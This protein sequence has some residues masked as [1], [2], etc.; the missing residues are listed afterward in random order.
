MSDDFDRTAYFDDLLRDAPDEARDLAQVARMHRAQAGLLEM[1]NADQPLTDVLRG[2][3]SEVERLIPDALAAIHLLSSEGHL[4]VTVGPSLPD[5]FRFAVDE[6]AV[7]LRVE[8]RRSPLVDRAVWATDVSKDE[9]WA[10][11]AA[12]AESHGI[13]ACWT[14]PA[15]DPG[16]GKTLA[17]LS[18]YSG[19]PRTPRPIEV[20]VLEDMAR[21]LRIAIVTRR[22]E[23]QWLALAEQNQRNL[24]RLTRL[25]EATSEGIFGTDADGRCTFINPAALRMLGIPTAEDAL[26]K[27]IH[28]L[29]RHTLPDGSDY[30][31]GECPIVKTLR[32]GQ[33]LTAHDELLIQHDGS[34]LPVMLS[35]SPK[36]E[37]KTGEVIGAV[38]VFDD[39][40]EQ[41]EYQRRLES[42]L[43]SKDE[44]IASIAHE[45]RTPLTA[46]LGFSEVLG[47]G[48]RQMEL[49]EIG[50]IIKL[51][52]REAAE[53]AYLVD[54]LLVAARAELGEI[55]LRPAMVD[56]ADEARHVL[57][58]WRQGALRHV[59]V[60]AEGESIVHAD[61]ARVR[62]ILRNLLANAV[63]YGGE[64][65]E[66]AVGF[67]G[68]HRYVDVIDDGPGVSPEE[69]ES[70]FEPY[71]RAHDVP[72][73]TASL[74]LGLSI[75]RKLAQ[76]M[77]GQLV[78]LRVEDRTHFRL[79]LPAP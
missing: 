76:A 34:A 20:H 70:V 55:T 77:G 4:T 50:D 14:I 79:T 7:Q 40:T 51:V 10:P 18:V 58:G 63:K 19:R 61:P 67:D 12:L 35:A 46:V 28:D 11:W 31:T 74:G 36:I 21:I 32:T 17:V 29:M 16:T 71:A 41:W 24:I 27:D 68:A 30:P 60:A 64:T 48:W 57:A 23:Q 15:V 56:M 53:V 39:R 22:S 44:F 2:V 26:E 52:S 72:G 73:L 6:Q 33:P 75:S 9:R 3:V 49:E 1:V 54:D 25:L 78:Y 43:T 65:I 45:L 69:A 42:A 5:D 47:D 13:R 66:V 37:S 8:G 38:V 62:Q 59:S